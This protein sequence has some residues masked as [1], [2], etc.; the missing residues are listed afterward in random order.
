MFDLGKSQFCR[1]KNIN[2]N[3]NFIA[4]ICICWTIE[5]YTKSNIII[6][7]GTD[8]VIKK[9]WTIVI[10]SYL[11]AGILVCK[12]GFINMPAKY[13]SISSQVL[14]IMSLQRDCNMTLLK[15]KAYSQRPIFTILSFQSST[16]MKS[17]QINMIVARLHT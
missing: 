3:I 1:V 2:I 11:Q 8:K 9:I 7:H 4:T 13:I 10:N 5:Q 16:S 15:A 6:L 12:E 17:V 14:Q